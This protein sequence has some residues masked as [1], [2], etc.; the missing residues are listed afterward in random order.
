MAFNSVDISNLKL[1]SELQ[2]CISNYLLDIPWMFHKSL[3]L[4]IFEINLSCSPH[5]SITEKTD[6][7]LDSLF[8]NSSSCWMD[9]P[10]T[11]SQNEKDGLH[12]EFLFLLL[13]SCVTK[14]CWILYQM[15]P[16]S[17]SFASKFSFS[18]LFTNLEYYHIHFI[19]LIFTPLPQ[20]RA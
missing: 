2:I 3:R 8:L 6:A 15:S 18:S 7:V 16:K 20:W 9:S 5:S 1:S 19:S 13:T 4:N 17:I 14:S 12:H 10:F 11:W